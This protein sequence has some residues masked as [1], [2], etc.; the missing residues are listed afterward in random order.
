MI[1][2]Y[3]TLFMKDE[4]VYLISIEL[5]DIIISFHIVN[6]LLQNAL[7]DFELWHFVYV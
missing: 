4:N 2:F 7:V 5:W 3:Q 1:E 6:Y